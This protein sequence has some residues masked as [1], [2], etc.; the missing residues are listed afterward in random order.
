MEE[1]K[2]SQRMSQ[3]TTS[4]TT[5]KDVTLMKEM[6]LEIEKIPDYLTK[7]NKSFQQMLYQA[8][9]T[10]TTTT[11]TTWNKN[12]NTHIESLRHIAILIYKIMFIQV[13]HALW[14]AYL[15]SGMGQLIIPS[16]AKQFYS[17]AVS[18]W[19]KQIKTFSQSTCGKKTNREHDYYL[20]FAQNHLYELE[21]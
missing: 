16:Q 11:T 12:N 4:E 10:I 8:V 19:P 15:K 13:Y 14:A 5:N 18:I 7:R 1:Q 17:T 9:S 20:K 6:K 2:L 21:Q 3:L